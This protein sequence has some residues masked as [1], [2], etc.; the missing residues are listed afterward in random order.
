MISNYITAQRSPPPLMNTPGG[1]GRSN[2]ATNARAP[3]AQNGGGSGAGS[4]GNT[5]GRRLS[6]RAS[7][8]NK[9]RHRT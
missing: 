4:D 3:S 6:R 7:F 9:L 5:S 8:F 1:N 2:E